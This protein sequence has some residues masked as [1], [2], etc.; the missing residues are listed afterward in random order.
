[1]NVYA[2]IS[3]VNDLCNNKKK[4]SK[5]ML[6]PKCTVIYR[7]GFYNFLQAYFTPNLYTNIGD[8]QTSRLRAMSQDAFSALCY[9]LWFLPSMKLQFCVVNGSRSP[10]NTSLITAH[11]GDCF[12][13]VADRQSR[14][15]IVL[16]PFGRQV[17]PQILCGYWAW[18]ALVKISG[19]CR[20]LKVN[21]STSIKSRFH[22]F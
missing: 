4:T 9:D 16:D 18:S 14:I 19:N 13:L 7:M 17:K 11:F 20:S 22:L 6:S 15:K 2:S 1:M 3:L 5:F 12:I 10:G 8:W 21:T